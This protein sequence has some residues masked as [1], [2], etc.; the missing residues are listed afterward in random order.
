M[1]SAR[2]AFAL[3]AASVAGCSVIGDQDVLTDAQQVIA[4]T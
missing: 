4:D 3:C 2:L 1:R